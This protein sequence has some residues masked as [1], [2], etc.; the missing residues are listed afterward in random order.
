MRNAKTQER[1]PFARRIPSSEVQE[2]YRGCLLGRAVG[3]ALG[4]P[5]EFMRHEE[6]LR[7]FGASGIT[8]FVPVY[9]KLGAITDDTQMTLSTAEGM[10]R[11]FIRD[12]L[13]G[14]CHAP[15]VID[16]AY[17]R[18]LHTRGDHVHIAE[19]WDLDIRLVRYRSPTF[20][21]KRLAEEFRRP[22]KEPDC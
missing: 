12:S 22:P 10:L 21:L 20:A 9:G 1:I 15:S 6:I 4:A 11:G 17:L 5:V 3:D 18:W 13:R 2:R 8:D 14:L 19:G 16:Y 7:R